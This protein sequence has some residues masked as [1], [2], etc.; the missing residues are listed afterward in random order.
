MSHD[1]GCCGQETPDHAAAGCCSGKPADQ[2]CKTE[3]ALLTR[4]EEFEA[5]P[6][7]RLTQ[8]YRRGIEVIDQRVL[9]LTEPQLDTAFL[10]DSGAGTWPA[11]VL[12]GHCADAELVFVHRMRRA[13]GEDNPVVA[14]WDEDAFIDANVYGVQSD[15]YADDPEADHARVLHS[16]GGHL[17]VIHTLR[18]WHSAWLMGLSDAAWGRRIM[19]PEYGPMSVKRVLSYAT[20]H[21]E[22]H[23]RFLTLK[24]DKMGIP[25]IEEH[26]G[27]CGHSHD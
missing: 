6:E 24:L 17:A 21:L 25:A 4:P 8:R 15:G 18:Q 14:L 3:P 22:H 7:V 20:W 26:A 27:G 1:Q 2:C 9:R 12:L 23:A 11:R 19:H 10:P 16:V 13:V 5:L